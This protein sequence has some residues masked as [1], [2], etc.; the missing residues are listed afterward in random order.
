MG[1]QAYGS[2]LCTSSRFQHILSANRERSAVSPPPPVLNGQSPEIGAGRART[3][4]WV[5]IPMLHY[6][7]EKMKVSLVSLLFL[8]ILSTAFA[9]YIRQRMPESI[10]PLPNCC[11]KYY[12]KELPKKR[13][14]G[15]KEALNCH[16]PAII[17]VTKKNV[18]VCANPKEEWVKEYIKDPKIPLMPHK[19]LA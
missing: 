1:F 11:H 8:A 19:N 13:V 18:E 16:L 7:T 17:F 12:E 6:P 5:G 9:L 4:C 3:A 14:A 2:E 15:Y 10:K